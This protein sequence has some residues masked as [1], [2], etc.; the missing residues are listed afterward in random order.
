MSGTP[1]I[2]RDGPSDHTPISLKV[3]LSKAPPPRKGPAKLVWDLNELKVP[4][5]LAKYRST[6][7]T[8]TRAWM[9]WR[10]DLVD[11]WKK[12]STM[13]KV[14]RSLLV[15]ILYEASYLC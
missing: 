12:P 7:E 4:S 3:L 10:D 5:T 14:S 1:P 8:L 15:T 6:M 11:E 2:G 9:T 13:K